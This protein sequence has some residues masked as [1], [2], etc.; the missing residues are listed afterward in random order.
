MTCSVAVIDCI[1]GRFRESVYIYLNPIANS[2]NFKVMPGR[3]K[4]CKGT[5]RGGND[6]SVSFSQLDPN[7]FAVFFQSCFIAFT[8][9]L[10]RSKH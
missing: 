5:L 8:S 10:I 4:R 9:I 2:V 6:A 1:N 7:L 3:R